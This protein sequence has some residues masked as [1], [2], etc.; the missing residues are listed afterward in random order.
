MHTAQFLT[1]HALLIHPTSQYT[2]PNNDGNSFVPYIGICILD[3]NLATVFFKCNA[4]DNLTHFQKICMI[5][6]VYKVGFL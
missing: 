5:I 6:P 2:F 3:F 1:A 4:F